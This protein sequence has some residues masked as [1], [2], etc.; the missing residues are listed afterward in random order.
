M[1]MSSP[2]LMTWLPIFT[3]AGR[4]P[5]WNSL[6]TQASSQV[7][8]FTAS[9][10]ASSDSGVRRVSSALKSRDQVPRTSPEKPPGAFRYSSCVP[11]SA[12]DAMSPFL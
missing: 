3:L 9:S 6:A 12:S 4:S 7:Q 5:I 2:Q 10:L 1:K 11:L 8:F